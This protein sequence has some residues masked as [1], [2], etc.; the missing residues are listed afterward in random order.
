M[1]DPRVHA[2]VGVLV[3][4]MLG[5]AVF[6]ASCSYGFVDLIQPVEATSAW[7]AILFW[8]L[9]SG[10]AVLGTGWSVARGRTRA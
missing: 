5:Y 8:C 1:I 2:L 10:G 3:G 9:T 6:L 4:A 7:T